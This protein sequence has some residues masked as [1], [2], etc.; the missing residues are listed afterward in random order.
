MSDTT[1][2]LKEPGGALG[3]YRKTEVY[4]A[5]K[6]TLLLMMYSGVIRSL[7]RAID[8]GEKGDGAERARF[9]VKAQEIVNEL[10]STLNF[11]V[12][13]D[14]AKHLD[15]LYAFITER[16]VQATVDPKAE[17]IQDALKVL[18]TLNN[19]WEEAIA[20]LRKEK[21]AA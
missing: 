21:A 17:P 4:T 3:A 8:A 10:R 15:S 12:G 7:K 19:A 6:E 1:K 2:K 20:S 13:G 9:I 16:L 18:T 14:I 11:D 5:N